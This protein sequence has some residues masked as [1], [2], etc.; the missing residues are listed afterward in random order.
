M[1]V[2]LVFATLLFLSLSKILPVAVFHGKL[3]YK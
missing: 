3:S 2:Y 1:K